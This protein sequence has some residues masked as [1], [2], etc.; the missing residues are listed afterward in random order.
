[1]SL[2]LYINTWILV[3]QY[4]RIVSFYKPLRFDKQN[5]EDIIDKKLAGKL[6]ICLMK[7][8]EFGNYVLRINFYIIS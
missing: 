1:M 4:C 5:D 2:G 3:I 6:R 8:A 7:G